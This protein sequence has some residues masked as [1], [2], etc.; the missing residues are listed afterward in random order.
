MFFRLSLAAML[1]LGTSGCW[2]RQELENLGFVLALG[3]D[4]APG[5]RM[6]ITAQVAIPV[7]LGGGAAS[8]GGQGGQGPTVQVVTRTAP[9]LLEAFMSINRTIGRRLTLAQNRLIVFG[10]DTAQ[11]GLAGYMALITRYREF[12]RTMQIA[13]VK[14]RAREALGFSPTIE[15]DPAT[16][17]LDQMRLAQSTGEAV[18][19]NVNDFVRRMEGLGGSP[20]A[21]YFL[22]PPGGKNAKGGTPGKT[23]KEAVEGGAGIRVGGIAVFRGDRMVGVYSPREVDYFLI[24]ADRFSASFVDI[25]DPLAPGCKVIVHLTSARPVVRPRS[26]GGLGVKVEVKAEADLI[27][28]ENGGDYLA[29]QNERRL[30][31]ALSATLARRMRA[32]LARAQREFRADPFAFG[33]RFRPLLATWAAWEKLD[34]PGRFPGVP[35]SIEARVHLRRFGLQREAPVPAAGGQRRR[36]RT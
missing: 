7:R 4:A 11:R 6:E 8:G 23:G 28:T 21:A 36:Y 29:P 12:R 19:V 15:R 25:P 31:N 32:V 2:D 16:Y 3:L 30:E 20:F 14:G 24:L 27:G 13:I 35:F 5:G 33:D 26:R 34:W 17:L 9:T 1:L 10:E 22:P 18:M